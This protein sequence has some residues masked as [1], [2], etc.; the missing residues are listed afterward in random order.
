MSIRMGIFLLGSGILLVSSRA[1]LRD[2]RS[3]GF[4]RFF[5]FECLLGLVMLNVGTWFQRPASPLQLVSWILL[6]G[7]ILLAFDGFVMLKKLGRPSG[8]IETTTAIVERGV[9]RHI[10]HPLYAS[11]LCFAWGVFLKGPSLEG[12]SLAFGASLLLYLTARAEEREN[13][14][15]F[16]AAYGEYV[17]GTKMFI[18]YIF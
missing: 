18:P 6:G 16:G 10:R 13:F 7:S 5:A 11:L 12:G 8:S 15:K 4:F 1:S 17:N 9:Y 3:Y 14:D 2:P